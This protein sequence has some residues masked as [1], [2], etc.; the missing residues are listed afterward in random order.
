MTAWAVWMFVAGL[1]VLAFAAGWCGDG[2]RPARILTWTGIA[3]GAVYA[4]WCLWSHEYL[5]ALPAAA[6]ILAVAVG[7]SLPRSGERA[8]SEQQPSRHGG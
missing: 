1:A 6:G 5:A 3:S 7:E 4:V 8:E 2:S